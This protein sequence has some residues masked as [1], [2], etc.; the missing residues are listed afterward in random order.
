MKATFE[1]T[2]TIDVPDTF[3]RT[4]PHQH[5]AVLDAAW[6]QVQ[7]RDGYLTE[8][9]PE[10]QETGGFKDLSSYPILNQ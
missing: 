3:D 1:W 9:E 4:D 7:K 6:L 2:V 8:V 10:Y 5:K